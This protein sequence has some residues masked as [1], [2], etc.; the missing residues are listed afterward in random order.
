MIL[1]VNGDSHAA[2]AEINNNYTF[3][4]D[5]PTIHNNKD[6]HPENIVDSFGYLLAKKLNYNFVTNARSGASNDRI[7]RT[8]KEYLEKNNQNVFVLIGWSTTD[9]REFFINNEYYSFS[10]GYT[11]TNLRLEKEFK[12]YILSLDFKT[13]L[14]QNYYWHE[15]IYNFHLE[16]NQKNI[17]HLFFNTFTVFNHDKHPSRETIFYD[18]NQQMIGPYKDGETYYGWLTDNG[19]K[20]VNKNSYHFGAD[21]HKRWADRLYNWLTNYQLL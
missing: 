3:A 15:K 9:R 4:D 20:T 17:P 2:G 21:A 18:W 10:P 8:T 12:K 11:P 6:P 16:L 5:D 19:Y 14:D 13:Q 1:Y 7:L